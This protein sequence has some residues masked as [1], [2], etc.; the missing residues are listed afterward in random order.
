[1]ASA[2]FTRVSADYVRFKLTGGNTAYYYTFQH[3]SGN[4][5]VSDVS[6]KTGKTS[7]SFDIYTGSAGVYCRI[8]QASRSG[9]SVT[10]FPSS[11][12]QYV[13]KYVEQITYKVRLVKYVD[14]SY[15]AE[16]TFTTTSQIMSETA[17]KNQI[18][19]SWASSDIKLKDPWF[20]TLSG[21]RYDQ[22][23]G[24]FT[25]TSTSPTINVAYTKIVV[26]TYNYYLRYHANGGTGGP[27]TQSTLKTTATSVTF[28]VS[29]TEPTRKNYT[30]LGWSF[31]PTA[32]AADYVSG[33]IVTLNSG[34]PDRTLYAVWKYIPKYNYYL[35]Y[36]ANGGTG[37]PDTQSTL[38]TTATSVTFRV[39][40]TEPTRTN[41]TFLGWSFDP[42]AT[43]AD[44]V[45]G[46][47]VALNSGNPDRTLYAVW[48]KFYTYSYLYN[49]NTTDTVTNMPENQSA[50][51][52]ET[53]YSFNIRGNVPTRT[54]YVFNGWALVSS[55]G[56]SIYSP[57]DPGPQ[58][59]TNK[60][61]ITLYAQWSP[62]TYTIT[63]DYYDDT[64]KAG[65]SIS[66]GGSYQHGSVITL[67]ATPRTGYTFDGWYT[68]I[69]GVWT[70]VSANQN[71]DVTVTGAM[72]YYAKANKIAPTIPTATIEIT[73]ATSS[74]LSVKATLTNVL[75]FSDRWYLCISATGEFEAGTYTSIEASEQPFSYTF[76]GLSANTTYYFKVMN[77][78]NGQYGWQVQATTGTTLRNTFSWDFNNNLDNRRPTAKEWLRLITFIEQKFGKTV[79]QEAK[80]S[81]VIGG[82]LSASLFNELAIDIGYASTVGRGTSISRAILYNLQNEAN[83]QT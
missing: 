17:V 48:K 43:A 1:M 73:G 64:S 36:D 20:G 71:Y 2:S 57:N 81:V 72:T 34:N 75:T 68:Y 15:Q 3:K 65:L 28:R 46:D 60:T 5:W 9:G 40:S 22:Y 44:Y 52:F 67:T 26:P 31:D 24:E 83:R 49:A 19:S 55:G 33:D 8:V 13:D 63:V 35:R 4:S 25:F 80:N 77:F 58:L 30:F 53:T 42:T 23:E 37:E 27:D 38:K 54:G 7:Y 69:S 12:G 66:G 47:T 62:R 79:S 59:N 6:N 61:S 74:S 51:S 32:T 78:Y 18:P 39:S 82:T 11:S 76:T 29:S 41:Y 10:Y 45:G 56:G 50:S 14:N 16:T 21:C 70:R